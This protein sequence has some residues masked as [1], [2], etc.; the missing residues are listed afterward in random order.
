MSLEPAADCVDLLIFD[1]ILPAGFSPFRTIEYSH[2]LSFFN[3]KLVS[4]EGW[5][6]FVSDRPFEAALDELTLDPNLK[7]R[8]LPLSAASEVSGRL[9]YV[10][11]LMNAIKLV[12]Y[13][14]ARQ[15]PFIFQLYPG[16]GFLIDHPDSDKNLRRVVLSEYCR[17]VIVTQQLTRDYVID[18][19]GCDPGKVELTF[20]GVF[21]SRGDFDFHRDKKIFGRHKQTL[22]L[23]F[24]AH[25]YGHDVISKGYD[26]F[27]GIAGALSRHDPRLR[28]HVVGGYSATDI[29]LGDAA[30]KFTFYGV[31]ENRFFKDF[32]SSMDAI[33]SINRPGTLL[34]GAFDGFPT[35][36]CI[37]AGFHGVLNCVNDPLSLN[38][39]L[40]PGQ[41]FLLLD[42]DQNQSVSRL[43]QLLD[44]PEELYRLAYANWRAFRTIFSTDSQLW[45]RTRLIT[46]ELMRCNGNAVSTFQET[47]AHEPNRQ[48]AGREDLIRWVELE[49]ECQRL[50]DTYRDLERL[51]L[52]MEADRNRLVQF[53]QA[54]EDLEAVLPVREDSMFKNMVLR[55]FRKLNRLWG[56]PPR[57]RPVDRT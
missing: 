42:F 22:D 33:I 15:L 49:R 11:F 47:A 3:A 7:P 46:S 28:F 8:I 55:P 9:A 50:V 37:E 45:A 44:S 23:C 17:K 41:D 20:G 54:R 36:A 39:V 2:Y 53:I 27:V 48:R 43:R 31:Q 6:H 32:Y 52:A 56:Q 38:P 26:Q 40:R 4:T 30:E 12:P 34:P 13:F 18:R 35:G 29:P 21:E 57:R 19:I 10:T 16:G 14:E 25:K 51:Y 24:V 5:Y 1:D